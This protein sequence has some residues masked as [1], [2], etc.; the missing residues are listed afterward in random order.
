MS[1]E[2]IVKTEGGD[3]R[4]LTEKCEVILHDGEKGMALVIDNKDDDEHTLTFD[5]EQS[6]NL[7]MHVA[8]GVEKLSDLKC[9]IVV[10]GNKALN[11]ASM[12]IK[13]MSVGSMS[14]RYRTQISVLRKTSGGSSTSGG[15]S[16][17]EA[18]K[19]DAE[20]PKEQ[21]KPKSPEPA[22]KD[23]ITSSSTTTTTTTSTTTTSSSS[24]DGKKEEKKEQATSS[25]T[26][27]EKKSP[28]P[29]APAG[30]SGGKSYSSSLQGKASQEKDAPKAKAEPEEERKLSDT[31]SMFLRKNFEGFICYVQNLGEDPGFVT[32]DFTKS[33]NLT[34]KESP[35]VSKKGA[36]G[37]QI[38]VEPGFK[39]PFVK[40]VM[41]EKDKPTKVDF[42]AECSMD[43]S[44]HEASQMHA[45]LKA[46]AEEKAKA[47][48]EAKAKAEAGGTGG[49]AG[50]G[51][52]GAAG[53]KP[54]AGDPKAEA[55]ALHEA[56]KKMEVKQSIT[57]TLTF[58]VTASVDG[59]TTYLESKDEDPY[60]VTVDF[61]GCKNLA[62]KPC[63][64]VTNVG[65]KK[66]SMT[67]EPKRKFPFVKLPL[68][69]KAV[70]DWALT[71]NFTYKNDNSLRQATD[72][73]KAQRAKAE[74]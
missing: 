31:M 21:P 2:E 50:G 30:S 11:L 55:K 6:Q 33:E 58:Q 47:E 38:R 34:P 66:F 7:E 63:M 39:V 67:I 28:E 74:S 9:K 73:L 15:G 62:M 56:L 32:C 27:S 5:F 53:G 72:K 24:T 65:G 18:K 36:T 42:K 46:K 12:E 22:K 59:Y 57:D 4:P 8:K 13:D 14:L 48:A 70:T 49:A 37:Y 71:Y 61:E 26:T 68:E 23:E 69:D 16:S 25:T 60:V 19:D 41:K 1:E 10:P 45:K 35:N 52:G 43:L 29:A 17:S 40:L 20:A 51:A 44:A 64:N 3:R 54:G